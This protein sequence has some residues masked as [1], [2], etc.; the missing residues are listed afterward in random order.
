MVVLAAL[1]N[2]LRVV[3][4]QIEAASA[5]SCRVRGRREQQSSGC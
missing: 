3:G 4:K 2:T 5:S 1:T